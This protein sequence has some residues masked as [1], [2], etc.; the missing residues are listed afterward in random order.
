MWHCCFP[1]ETPL[2]LIHTSPLWLFL[3]RPL[4]APGSPLLYAQRRTPTLPPGLLGAQRSSA[5]STLFC[6]RFSSRSRGMFFFS[7]FKFDCAARR[8]VA[9]SPISP[10][11]C[12]QPPSMC[13]QRRTPTL[14]PGLL[15]AQHSSAGSTLPRCRFSSQSRGMFFFL[16]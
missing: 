9:R 7:F 15:G 3:P 8:H 12:A 5:G 14:P 16:F 6:Y 2:S 4:L 10:S 13:A 1:P 11:A